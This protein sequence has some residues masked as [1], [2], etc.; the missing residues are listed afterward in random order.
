MFKYIMAKTKYDN[1]RP[2]AAGDV[3]TIR[4]DDDLRDSLNAA[5]T[6]TKLSRSD[7]ARMSM[8]RG[9]KVLLAQLS[10]PVPPAMAS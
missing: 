6:T 4:V 1:R 7:L 10:T 5:A 3:I 2:A 9:L 8:E